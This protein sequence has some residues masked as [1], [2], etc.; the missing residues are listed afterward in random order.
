LRTSQVD[1]IDRLEQFVRRDRTRR[2]RAEQ[3]E[4]IAP[5]PAGPPDNAQLREIARQR[6]LIR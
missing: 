4:E 3:A 5:A 2:L 1:V 6:G